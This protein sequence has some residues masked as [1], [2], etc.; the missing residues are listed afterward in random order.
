MDE[1]GLA[2]HV[3]ESMSHSSKRLDLQPQGP[4]TRTTVAFSDPFEFLLAHAGSAGRRF[5]LIFLDLPRASKREK[6]RLFSSHEEGGFSTKE[7]AY[8]DTDY[9]YR[10]KATC[11][12]AIRLAL[13]SLADAGVILAVAIPDTYVSVRSCLDQELGPQK[14]LGELVY[15]IRTGG[16]ADSRWLSSEHETLLIYSNNPEGTDT[17]QVRKDEKELNK[18]KEEDD[19]GRYYWDT[20]SRKNARNFYPITCPDGSILEIDQNG[21]PYSWL[22]RKQTLE[23]KLHEGEAQIYKPKG[24]SEYRVRYKDRIKEFKI[25]RSLLLNQ[26]QL[27]DVSSNVTDDSKGKD[28]LTKAGSQEIK[29]F[30]GSNK[31]DYLKSS[32]YFSFILKVFG[33]GSRVLIPFNEY[34]SA[35]VANAGNPELGTSL[36][37]CSDKRWEEL[38]KWRLGQQSEDAQGSVCWLK[39]K[40][41]DLFALQRNDSE[42]RAFYENLVSLSESL[43]QDW[44]DL[45]TDTMVASICSADHLDADSPP[46]LH[47]MVHDFRTSGPSLLEGI[48]GL[49][50]KRRERLIDHFGTIEGV[51]RAK[52]ED[53]KTVEGLPDKVAEAVYAKVHPEASQLGLGEIV[54]RHGYPDSC[55]VV[56]WTA[57]HESVVRTRLAL[58][59]GVEVRHLPQH[60]C[61]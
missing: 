12:V 36:W 60:F 18:Y 34:G 32:A 7:V 37:V 17:F 42:T 21:N 58:G 46:E 6:A 23:E 35:T 3:L 28:L 55:P 22:W 43:S 33:A 40:P 53:L 15:Q 57:F 25:L 54:A 5:D 48:T 49:G 4:H 44:T 1:S 27:E 26:T 13:R 11:L 31:P 19:K 2:R 41:K 16:G 14:F 39:P 10:H 52:L 47:L 24:K 29:A 51:Q 45:S 9:P 30:T 8:D 38:A 20:F 61:Q 56:L 50:E 59:R